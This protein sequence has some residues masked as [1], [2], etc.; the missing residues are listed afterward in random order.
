M[1]NMLD[2]SKKRIFPE[3]LKAFCMEVMRKSGMREEDAQITADVLVT[4]DVWGVHSHGTKFLR[5]YMKR[6]QSGGLDPKAV[7]EIIAEGLNWAIV[8]GHSVMAMVTACMAMR[9]A[10]RKAKDAVIGYVGVQNS[11]HCGAVGYY[12]NMAVQEDMIGVAMTNTNTNMTVPNAKGS[13]IGNNPLAY[14]V[15]AGIEKPLLLDIATSAA[16]GGKIIAAKTLGKTIPDNWLVD[17]DG[18]PTTDPGAYLLGG[19]LLPMA[20]HKGYGLALLVEVLTSV[21]TGAGITRD[22]KS[23]GNELS[24]PTQTGHAFIAIN[25]GSIMPIEEFKTR[26]DRMIRQIKESPKAKGAERIFLPGEIEWEKY[27]KAFKEGIV[28]PEDVVENLIGMAEDW[29]ISLPTALIA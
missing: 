21:L 22:V 28:L 8:D 25:V 7:P 27:E 24:S 2:S 26:M 4:T 14:A 17:A 11:C 13:V 12:A 3:D 5:L 23:W 10:M 1:T 20:G 9:T 16:A 15:P 18:V 6:V 29:G 19:S